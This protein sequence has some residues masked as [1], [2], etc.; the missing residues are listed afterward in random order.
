MSERPPAE[1]RADDLEL[2]Q[3]TTRQLGGYVLIA[4]LVLVLLRFVRRAARRVGG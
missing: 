3:L 2:P 1:G 4:A